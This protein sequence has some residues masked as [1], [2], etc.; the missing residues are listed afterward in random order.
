MS[1]DADTWGRL[2]PGVERGSS[3]RSRLE[4]LPDLDE[5]PTPVLGPPTMFDAPPT[6]VD[7]VPTP[8]AEA[9]LFFEDTIPR[10]V[11][12]VPTGCLELEF[13]AEAPTEDLVEMDELVPL[14]REPEVLPL[15]W[16]AEPPPRPKR[17]WAGPLAIA[18][19]VVAGIIGLVLLH[20]H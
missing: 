17:R 6:F 2:Q 14:C 4:R 12:S 15:H 5:E 16:A 9:P 19:M 1:S 11:P 8:T 7:D 18:L 20:L 13:E 3:L 10:R